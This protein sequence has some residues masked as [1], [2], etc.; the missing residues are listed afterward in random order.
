MNKLFL[1]G[2]S[3]LLLLGFGSV[4]ALAQTSAPPAT[5]PAPSAP[6]ANA[7]ATPV[8]DD[9]L[10]KFVSAA[11]KLDVVLQEQSGQIASLV[12]AG[13][14]K[15]ERFREIYLSKQNSKVKPKTAI[16][17]EEQKK[18][19][20]AVVKIMELQKKTQTKMGNIVEGEGLKMP[21]FLQIVNSIQNTPDLQKKVEQL[22]KS[23]K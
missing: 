20:Q 13:G 17:P 9:E 8:S 3:L 2:G 10:K 5:P 11:R 7:P 16:T 18:F 15:M 23:S 22:L 4:P 19:D 6:P 21:R 1:V 14:L 12:Q